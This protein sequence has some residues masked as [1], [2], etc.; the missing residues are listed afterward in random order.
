M[1]DR[2]Y[3]SLKYGV[4]D[5]YEQ[6]MCF[7]SQALILFQCGCSHCMLL[8]ELNHIKAV[9]MGLAPGPGGQRVSVVAPKQAMM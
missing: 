7:T 8:Q 3:L 6:P 4:A 2:H 5:P 9:E 1:R